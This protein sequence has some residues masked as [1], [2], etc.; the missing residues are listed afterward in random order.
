MASGTF[1]L[2]RLPYI[3][4]AVVID[5][6]KPYHIF[7][8]SLVSKKSHRIARSMRKKEGK[9][10]L[11]FAQK[12]RINIVY[13]GCS[14]ILFI[15]P[16]HLVEQ[17]GEVFELLKI[18]NAAF[19]TEMKR[20]TDEMYI[21]RNCNMFAVLTT[22]LEYAISFYG[23]PIHF[24]KIMPGNRWELTKRAIEW[25]LSRQETIPDCSFR[26]ET[27]SDVQ[28]RYFLDKI[29][30][31][32]SKQLA[33]DTVSIS[34]NFQHSF[35]QPLT[36]VITRM[37]CKPWL[38]INNLYSLNSQYIDIK[39]TKFTCADM[40][41]FLKNW[42]QGGNSELRCLFLRLPL[43]YDEVVLDGLEAVQRKSVNKIEYNHFKN[44]IFK[45]SSSFELKK[46]DG[47]IASLGVE[48]GINR[49]FVMV[50]WP[51]LL[52]KPYPAHEME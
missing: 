6:M 35:R 10:Y 38:N 24:V 42:L 2:Y 51:D 9:I 8:L 3:A 18:K 31:R 27:N 32:V 11:I 43:T 14:Y 16:D 41:S 28:F 45:F 4:L 19:N 17:E 1:S 37:G 21:Q 20:E 47:T 36:A 13:R 12:E 33:I 52:N 30:N 25:V 44:N 48:N 22:L 50:V 15:I 46:N 29:G 39:N 26:C 49:Q 7:R 23:Q 40:N 5:C 34:E